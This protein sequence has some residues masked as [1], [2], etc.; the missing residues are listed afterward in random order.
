MNAKF[1]EIN[2]YAHFKFTQLSLFETDLG[3]VSGMFI[4]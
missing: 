4:P 1:F 2:I 3:R